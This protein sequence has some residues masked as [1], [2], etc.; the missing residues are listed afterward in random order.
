MAKPSILWWLL[1]IVFLGLGGIIAYFLLK[2][3]D[4]KFAKKL[5]IAG[6]VLTG[7]VIGLTILS[8]MWL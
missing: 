8:F 7:L 3:R 4:K 5:L 6:L 2:D 1:P